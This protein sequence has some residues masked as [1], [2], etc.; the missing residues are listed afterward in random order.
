M[1]LYINEFYWRFLVWLPLV[2]AGMGDSFE[3]VFLIVDLFVGKIT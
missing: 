3:I 1:S 2:V